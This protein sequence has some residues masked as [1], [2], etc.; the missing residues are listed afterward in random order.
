M[1]R[2]IGRSIPHGGPIGYF[3]F[4]PGVR[5]CSVVRA[6]AHGVMDWRIDPSWWTHWLFLVS[7]R[8]E[9]LLCG[10]SV[11]SWCDGLAD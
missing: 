11:C 7:S 2:W 8:S 10:K 6:S 1:V 3:L 5:C 4:H 9:M